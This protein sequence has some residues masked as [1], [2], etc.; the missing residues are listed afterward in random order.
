MRSGDTVPNKVSPSLFI[1]LVRA[2]S[3]QPTTTPCRPCVTKPSHLS[4]ARLPTAA[5]PCQVRSQIMK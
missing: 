3:Q 2:K 4:A 5:R 1:G